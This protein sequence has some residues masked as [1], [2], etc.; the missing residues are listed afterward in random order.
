MRGARGGVWGDLLSGGNGVLLLVFE[1]LA[2]LVEVEAD[3]GL[4]LTL[5]QGQ[6]LQL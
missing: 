6:H 3:E 4:A 5:R 2:A 1:L